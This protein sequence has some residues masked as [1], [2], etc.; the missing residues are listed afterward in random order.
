[1]PVRNKP[2]VK[3]ACTRSNRSDGPGYEPCGL[4]AKSR[5]VQQRVG[6]AQSIR[7]WERLWKFAYRV[8]VCERSTS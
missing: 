1:M 3:M 8:W 7:G 6:V 4:N 5:V 2:N